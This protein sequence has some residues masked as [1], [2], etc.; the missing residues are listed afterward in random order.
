MAVKKQMMRLN[1]GVRRC[2]FSNCRKKVIEVA[3]FVPLVLYKK[4]NA[5]VCNLSNFGKR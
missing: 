1:T 3:L 2:M 4:N 5:D